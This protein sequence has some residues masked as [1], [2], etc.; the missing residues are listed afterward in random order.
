MF[1][2][3]R[4][5]LADSPS[6]ENCCHVKMFHLLPWQTQCTTLASQSLIDYESLCIRCQ[7]VDQ[8]EQKNHFTRHDSFVHVRQMFL[9]FHSRGAFRG[10]SN[11]IQ[12]TRNTKCSEKPD[13][14][15]AGRL[16]RCKDVPPSSLTMTS[17]LYNACITLLIVH[18]CC[19]ATLTDAQTLGYIHWSQGHSPDSERIIFTQCQR[20]F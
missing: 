4:Y 7:G 2:R 13:G 19:T 18:C 14:P 9:L 8:A 15:L 1:T 17:T 5:Y 3:T 6:Q 10:P 20:P 16:V 12:F 11:P